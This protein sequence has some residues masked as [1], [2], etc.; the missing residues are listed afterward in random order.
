MVSFQKML[1]LLKL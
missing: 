1:S